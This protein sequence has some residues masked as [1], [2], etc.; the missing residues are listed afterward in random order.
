MKPAAKGSCF[1]LIGESDRWHGKPLTR[2]SSHSREM[3]GGSMVLKAAH[4]FG[5]NSHIHTAKILRLRGLLM[6]IEIV[7][8]RTR[9][10]TSYPF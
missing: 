1:D 7:D 4:G 3:P 5:A 2:R 9:S 10:M 6:I 8:L